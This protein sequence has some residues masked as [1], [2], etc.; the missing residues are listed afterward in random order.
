VCGG[1]AA[2]KCAANEVC[3][4]A[5]G[6]CGSVKDASGTC[7]ARPQVCAAIYQ[8][9]CGCDGKTYGN[10]CERLGAGVSKLRDGK[11]EMGVEVGLGEACGG[12]TREPRVCKAG[13]FCE[14][15]GTSCG[16][17]DAGGTCQPIPQACDTAFAPVCG[18]DGKTYSNDCMRRAAGVSLQAQGEC[19]RRRV[20]QAGE[21][22]GGIAGIGCDKGLFCDPE[23]NQCRGADI[24]G[25][26]KPRSEACT[27]DFR[28]VCGCN[29]VTYSNDC[30]R[31]AA[32]VAK[33][34]DGACANVVPAL[35]PTGVWGGENV[36]LV[37]RDAKS[38]AQIV[39]SCAAGTIVAPLALNP[40]G[41]FK[42]QGRY[43]VVGGAQ[44][45]TPPEAQKVTFTGRVSGQTM[46]L[47]LTRDGAMPV[48]FKLA[49][50]VEGKILLCP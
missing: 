26:C 30:M 34:A 14:I 5:N 50:N 32:G 46:E 36:R 19:T 15:K 35:L 18:C 1:I 21:M 33:Q 13:L 12:F 31:I 22:C 29:G 4:L 45:I 2:I 42:W 43:V 20:A 8:P 40:D 48:L 17:N 37:V 9:V 7:Q 27:K 11:C 49:H 28:P 6:I 3:V 10:D 23:A 44:P 25:V 47:Q 38:D 39:F 24:G 41:S 16:A